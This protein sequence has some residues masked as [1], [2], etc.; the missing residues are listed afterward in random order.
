MPGSSE[1]AGVVSNLVLTVPLGDDGIAVAFADGV[2]QLD[3]HWLAE[4]VQVGHGVVADL[5]WQRRPV[6]PRVVETRDGDPKTLERDASAASD[7]AI[8]RLRLSVARRRPSRAEGR[9]A[10]R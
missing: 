6:R 8:A 5:G 1:Y 10:R 9:I 4:P 2:A 3:P 7:A